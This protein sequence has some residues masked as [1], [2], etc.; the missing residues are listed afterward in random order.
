[1][2]DYAYINIIYTLFIINNICITEYLNE[3]NYA[4]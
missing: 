4:K 1:M 3:K 2:R